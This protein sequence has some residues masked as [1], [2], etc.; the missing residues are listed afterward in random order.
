VNNK[1]ATIEW[2]VA[3][4]RTADILPARARFFVIWQVD[5]VK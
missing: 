5:T 2:Q 4:A 3:R 1:L